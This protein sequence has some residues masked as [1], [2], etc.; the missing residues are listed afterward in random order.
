MIKIIKHYLHLVLI[1]V[2]LGHKIVPENFQID[3]YGVD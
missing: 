1:Y 3:I 2:P